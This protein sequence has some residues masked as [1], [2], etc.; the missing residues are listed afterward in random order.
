MNCASA[1]ERFPKRSDKHA[2][3]VR[4]IPL[5]LRSTAGTTARPL[6]G[7]ALDI[8]EACFVAGP[9]IGERVKEE[10][11]VAAAVLEEGATARRN[12]CIERIWLRFR[13][14]YSV[15]SS[16]HV[17][18]SGEAFECFQKT[19]LRVWRSAVQLLCATVWH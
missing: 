14:V 19:V 10:F 1:G 11:T 15:D 16:V 9:E 12:E 2:S 5:I 7:S 13:R 18:G 8:D 17:R 3:G 6:D 4:P